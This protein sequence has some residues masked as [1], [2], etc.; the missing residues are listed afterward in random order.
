M[1][2][3]EYGTRVVHEGGKRSSRK[4]KYIIYSLSLYLH[5]KTIN[6]YDTILLLYTREYLPAI[7]Y[8]A[9]YTVYTLR[10]N[11]QPRITGRVNDAIISAKLDK[12]AAS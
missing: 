6:L 1:R 11:V 4:E 5:F 9:V 7:Y 8:Y 2:E 10:N 3:N 12:S